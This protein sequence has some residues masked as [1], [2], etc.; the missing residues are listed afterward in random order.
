LALLLSPFTSGKAYGIAAQS[1]LHAPNHTSF[2]ENNMLT[3]IALFAVLAI[4]LIGF[5]R[6][7][8][9]RQSSDEVFGGVCSG[10]ARH[11]GTTPNLVRVL[12]VLLALCT[13]GSVVL[14]YILLCFVLPKD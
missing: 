3:G 1:V 8:I 13:G 9:R 14:A 6:A 11:F 5:S 7:G 10:I 4:V 2:K 12:T